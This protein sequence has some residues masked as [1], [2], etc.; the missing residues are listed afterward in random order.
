MSTPPN[1]SDDDVQ[2]CR[3]ERIATSLAFENLGVYGFDSST[4]FQKTFSNYPLVILARLCR[5]AIGRSPNSR[6]YILRNLEGIIT[7]GEMLLVLGRPGSGCTTLLKTLAGDT[8]GLHV[9]SASRLNYQGN[10]LTEVHKHPRGDYVYLPESDVHFHHLTVAQTS[11]FAS[12][13]RSS[14]ESKS[15]EGITESLYLQH[16]LHTK[17]GNHVIRGIS[18]GERKRA[19]IAEILVGASRLQCW[20]NSTRGLDSANALRF[21]QTL[22]SSAREAGTVAVATLY[23]VS[24]D[25]YNCFDKVMILY[26]GREIFY[27]STTDA[28]AYFTDLGFLCPKRS[29]TADFLC[30][31]TDPVQRMIDQNSG[32]EVPR[33]SEE[34]ARRWV[35]SIEREKLMIEIQDYEH[36]YPCDRTKLKRQSRQ[37]LSSFLLDSPSSYKLD[38]FK[39]IHLCTVRAFQRLFQDLTPPISGIVGNVIISVILGSMFYNMP[40]DTSS[41]FGRGVLLFFTIL[42]NTLLASFEGVQL[43]D[44]RPIVERHYRFAFY[45]RSAE[46]IASMLCDLP[47]KILLTAG[48]NIPFYFLA[49][50]RRT[51]AAFLTFYLF[52]F[53]SLLTGSMLYRT[54]GA[55]S[56]TLTASIAP[57]SDFILLLVIYTGFVLP[58]PSMHPWLRWFGY[59]NPVGYAFESLM[60]NEFD[61]IQF[62]CASFVPDGPGYTNTTSYQRTCWSTGATTGSDIVEGRSYLAATFHYYPEHL[63]RNLGILIGF[64]RSKGDVLIF[65]KPQSRKA[66]A[67]DD[68]EAQRSE[69]AVPGSYNVPST[70]K[71]TNEYHGDPNFQKATFVWDD[72]NYNIK[73]EKGWL[74]LLDD[75]EGWIE[76]GTVTALMGESGAGKTTLLNVLANRAGVGVVGGEMVVDARFQ[77]DGFAR[78]VGYAQQQDLATSTAT[79]KET[80]IFN[81]RLRQPQRYTDAEK[82]AY[83]E[84]V[85]EKLEMSE[86]ADAVV[87]VQG[88]GLNIEQRKRVTIGIEL[89]ARPE[90]LLFL[91]EPTSG[92]DSDTAWSVCRLLRKLADAGQAILCTIHQPSGTIFEMFDKLLFIQQG[93]S[94]YFGEI[95]PGSRTVV[96]YFK[97]NGIADCA[98]DAN[99]AEWLMTITGRAE[100]VA[101]TRD[102]PH[103]WATSPE[104]QQ[105]K[106]SLVER[107]RRLRA[108]ASDVPQSGSRTKFAS[109]YLQQLH[110]V[111]KRNFEQDWRTPAYLY[112]KL[113]LALG[114]SLINGFS[115]YMSANSLQGVQN[116]IFSVFLLFTL[117]SSLVQLIMPQF[118]ERRV[119]YELTERPSRTYRWDVFILSNVIS[120]IPSQTVLAIIQF[121]TWYYPVGMYRN[122]LST[123][124]LNERSGLMC[125]LLWSYML[126]S[127]TFSQMVATV[128]PDAA[129][130]INISSLLYTLS[131]IFCGVLVAPDALPRF[132]IF[133]YRSTPITYFINAMVSTGIAGV[134]V[135]CS[136][137][138]IVRFDPPLGQTCGSYLQDYVVRVGGTLLNPSALRQCQLCP[139]STTDN[140]I[141]RIGVFYHDRWR[142][143]GISLVYSVINVIGALVLYWAFRVPKGARHTN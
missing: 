49:N 25:I 52:A 19:S 120:E 84:E 18:G 85:L 142:D 110:Q 87:G 91:D 107:K 26:E 115:F 101:L 4:N 89:A 72:L 118:L 53:T 78:K 66:R 5:K 127:S 124:A 47:N 80:L 99:P 79:V 81:A 77:N 32:N 9:D 63:W 138:E 42:T 17:I 96:E 94:I 37:G 95:G 113:F 15:I 8:Y 100:D 141:A 135:N 10:S 65:K 125:L 12:R 57:G 59:L 139:V 31:I 22:R 123:H 64:M 68:Q 14:V 134:S 36:E 128:M 119:L 27:G 109:T 129:T 50:M 43:W 35:A 104:R 102:W 58:V 51:P 55:M 73:T 90:L 70:D 29:T 137:E 46:A 93:R 121:I 132:W 86:F 30:S 39:E 133:M 88:E 54:I 82:L 7:D 130:G 92:L 98:P 2:R 56:R 105:I 24:E 122:A 74:R 116:Q 28:K 71:D 114:A 40:R 62:P 34:F 67:M 23:Q 41:F 140:V 1:Q 20:D 48:F 16:T 11:G 13:A 111:T 61:G 75:V 21:V 108:S 103:I 97:R 106:E 69:G 136:A 6:R 112:S 45:H 117:H 3:R 44:H 60:I 126:F 131:L 143:L 83:V 38:M 76:P 33:T